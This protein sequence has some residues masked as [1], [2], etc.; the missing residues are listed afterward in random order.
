MDSLSRISPC[1]YHAVAD[2][3]HFFQHFGLVVVVAAVLGKVDQRRAVRFQEGFDIP[4][5]ENQLAE[6][7]PKTGYR[8]RA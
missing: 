1:R 6:A 3:Q 2:G 4:G 5:K 7:L 8:R